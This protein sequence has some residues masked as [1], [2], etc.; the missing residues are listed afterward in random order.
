[1][2]RCETPIPDEQL[3][4]Y[5]VDDDVAANDGPIEAHL[6]ACGDC[7]ARL[8]VIASLGACVADLAR[9]GRITGLVSRSLINRLQREGVTLRQYSIAPGETVPCVVF[10]GDDLVITALRGDFSAARSVTVSVTGLGPSAAQAFEDLPVSPS[11]GEMFL[12]LPGT[13][14]RQLP[15]TRV[16]MTVTSGDTAGRL[17]GQYV[18][19][20]TAMP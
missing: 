13:F 16:E 19:D 18:L 20:H 14:V 11:E 17:I 9:Q 12:A 7:A 10:P 2:G 5:W 3:I 4:V 8:G 1:M 6:F 15:S